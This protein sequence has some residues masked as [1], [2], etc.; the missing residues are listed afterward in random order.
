MQEE[1]NEF[2]EALY[3]F[4]ANE[5]K[6]VTDPIYCQEGIKIVDARNHIFRLSDTLRTDEAED[7]YALSD[8]CIVDEDM[9]TVPNRQRMY[10]IARNHSHGRPN[11]VSLP[12]TFQT[13]SINSSSTNTPS[14]STRINSPDHTAPF[15]RTT[16]ITF[17]PKRQE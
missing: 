5:I 14:W 10:R 2:V 17:Q 15:V 8:L 12:S 11:V 6:R 1:I 16:Q 9:Q 3:R 4:V 13:N 7:T